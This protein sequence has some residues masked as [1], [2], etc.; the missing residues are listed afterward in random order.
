MNTL[1]ESQKE[2][3]QS[4]YSQWLASNGYRARRSQREMIAII[5][6]MLAG[7]E[8][9]N[10]GNRRSNYNAHLALIEAGTGTGKTIAYALPAL[11]M[12]RELDKRLVLSTATINLQ[13]QLVSKDLPD[14]AANAGIDFTYALA[15]G[16]QRYLCVNKLKLRL[17]DA[18]R[19]KTELTLFPDEESS[20]SDNNIA[21]LQSLDQQYH[22]TRWD[23]DQDN[24]PES[25]AHEHWRLVAADRPSCS[26]K[27]CV[28]YSNCAL[29]RARDAVRNADV[30]VANH[31]LVL[32]DLAAGGGAILPPPEQT[33]FVFDEAHHLPG[34]SRNHFSSR[35]SLLGESGHL[36]QTRKVMARIL[37]TRAGGVKSKSKDE[38]DSINRD[39]ETVDNALKA[40]LDNTGYMLRELA[41]TSPLDD[42]NRLR[43]ANGAVPA[44]VG[45][46]FDELAQCYRARQGLLHRL[47]DACNAR[48]GSE[49]GNGNAE[50]TTANDAAAGSWDV[51]FAA[52]GQLQQH[53]DAALEVCSSYA[54]A[55]S[56]RDD[57][58]DYNDMNQDGQGGDEQSKESAPSARWL[59]SEDRSDGQDVLVSSVP[60]STASILRDILW[61]QCFASVLTSATLAPLGN[62]KHFMRRIGYTDA[63]SA[64]VIHG[65]LNFAEAQFYVPDM[66]SEP[67]NAS[68]HT[69][70]I[71]A[72]LPELIGGAKGALVLFSSRAQ[73]EAVQQGVQGFL[74]QQLLVQGHSSRQ[75]LVERHKKSIDAG[76]PSVIF[77]LASFAEGLDLPGDYC[78]EVVIAK[79]PFAV[80]TDPVDVA[81]GEWVESRGGNAFA[82]I[83]LPEVSM[84]LMQASGRL[85]RN[86][87]DTGRVTLLDTRI[88]RKYYGKQLLK[89]LPPFQRVLATGNKSAAK[90]RA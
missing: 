90:S 5:A 36:L 63:S 3:I 41:D 23:G 85:L 83:S 26:G 87:S 52:V 55:D 37:S 9:D 53:C 47:A 62:F 17:A 33:I 78:S 4:S 86:E 76:E 48:V 6:R 82:D 64:H 11:L 80:P 40:A 20:L 32:A 13:E 45:E 8:V 38:F 71:I 34:K 56:A 16:R 65:Q 66:Q 28:H 31:D 72:L 12:A 75:A 77:G 44:A 89:A 61:K 15:K 81:M 60:L 1:S 27:K 39:L 74:A 49:G 67:G 24:L 46:G 79:L 68:A 59:Q 7:I 2:L 25:V 21:Q 29:F 88:V 18:A 35:M 30:V 42:D 50:A 70:E 51:H 73:M 84:R 43:F 22:E 19:D 54:N 58:A 57:E 69:E 14:L 10:E